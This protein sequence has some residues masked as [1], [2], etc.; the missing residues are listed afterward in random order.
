MGKWNTRLNFKNKTGINAVSTHS[1]MKRNIPG[2]L[3]FSSTVLYSTYSINKRA[4]Q[5]FE[6]CHPRCV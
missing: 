5:N 6:V 1:D 3:S 2:G 4:E